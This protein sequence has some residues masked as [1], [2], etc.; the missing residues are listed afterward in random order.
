MEYNPLITA[1]KTMTATIAGVVGVIAES[2]AKKYLPDLPDGTV[3]A[4]VLSI[5]AA[6][7]NWFKNKGK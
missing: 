3:T 4:L 1:R 7:K 5:F 2:L 6:G